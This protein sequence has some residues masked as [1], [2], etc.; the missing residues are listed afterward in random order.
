MPVAYSGVVG[1]LNLYGN[2]LM[3]L[4]LQDNGGK[5]NQYQCRLMELPPL[6]V[7]G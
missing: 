7:C 1:L 6:T 2:R 3:A 5:H 4:L